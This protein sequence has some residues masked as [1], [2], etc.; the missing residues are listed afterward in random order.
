MQ[1]DQYRLLHLAQRDITVHLDHLQCYCAILGIINQAQVK[2]LVYYAML[3][4][5][6]M[7]LI[8][9]LKL[10]VQKVIIVLMELSILINILAQQE[11]MVLQLV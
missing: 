11:H 10:S 5:T 2:Q 4:I 7:E 8:Q 9:Q 3:D 6:V 1:L